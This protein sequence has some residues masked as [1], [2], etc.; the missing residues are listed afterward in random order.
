MQAGRFACRTTTRLWRTDNRKKSVMD[1]QYTIGRNTDN[2]ISLA[3]P[4]VSGQHAVVTVVSDNILVLEDVGSTNGTFVNGTRVKRLLI[5][6]AD[7]VVLGNVPLNLQSLFGSACGP[8]TPPPPK[9][10]PNDFTDEFAELRE[11]YEAYRR[12]KLQLQRGDMT[13]STALRAGLALIPF[14]GCA[15][16]ILVSGAITDKEKEFALNEEFQISYVCPK[17]KRFLGFLPWQNLANQKRCST[18][19]TVWVAG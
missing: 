2:Q 3:Q 11:V 15:L 19:K 9:D 13:A 8:P 1:K 12:T 5:T 18:C 6:P 10:D 4:Q 16:G 7:R 17:C 14:V